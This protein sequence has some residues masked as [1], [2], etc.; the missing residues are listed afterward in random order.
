MNASMLTAD[1]ITHLKVV[2]T[3]LS[4]ALIVMLIAITSY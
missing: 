2:T 4:A 1:R 3:G